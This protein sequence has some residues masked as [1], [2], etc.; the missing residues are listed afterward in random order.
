MFHFRFNFPRIK[1]ANKSQRQGFKYRYGVQNRSPPVS[2]KIVKIGKTGQKSV[3]I[4]ISNFR[5]MQTGRYYRFIDTEIEK[6]V[7]IQNFEKS[8][9]NQEKY[10]K[11][12]KKILNVLVKKKFQVCII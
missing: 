3:Q 12:L 8:L 6:P 1:M 9:K 2:P 11:K 4:Q 5:M 7:Q 10:Y